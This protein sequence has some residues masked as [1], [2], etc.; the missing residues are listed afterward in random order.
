MPM[1]QNRQVDDYINFTSAHYRDWMYESHRLDGSL[2]DFN[3]DGFHPFMTSF[4]G[5]EFLEDD[6]DRD[7]YLPSWQFAPPPNT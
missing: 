7:I 1:V 6:K 5:G 4:K 3:P 2:E